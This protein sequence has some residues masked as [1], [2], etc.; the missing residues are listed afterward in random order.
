MNPEV[1]GHVDLQDNLCIWLA[2][3]RL[4]SPASNHSY[5]GEIP[6]ICS[7]TKHRKTLSFDFNKPTELAFTQESHDSKSHS[8]EFHF[9]HTVGKVE[10]LKQNSPSNIR[11]ALDI[12]SSDSQ[13]TSSE[14]LSIVKSGSALT[15]KTP[16]SVPR[17]SSSDLVAGLPCIY[18]AA[19]ISVPPG[20]TLE[21]LGINTETL[22]VSFYPGLDYAI[23][24]CTEI[25]AHSSSLSLVTDEPPSIDISSRETSIHLNSGSVSG[26]YPLYDILDVSTISGSIDI[27]VEP[28]DA[29]KDN[30]QPAILRLSS[31]SGSIRALTSR[32]SV[33]AR[34]YQTTVK[35]LSGGIDATLLHGSRTLLRSLN[36]RIN[37]DLYPY[38][39]NNSRTDINTH[40]QSGSTDIT[41]HSSLSHPTDPIQ[42]LYSEHH[43]LSGS[44]NLWYPAEWQ[45]TVKS[46]S[47]SGSIDLEWDGLRVVKDEKRGWIKRTVE[48]V[49]GEGGS[50]LIASS[51]SG[52]VTLGGD[53]ERGVFAGRKA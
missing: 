11:I 50:Q 6:K 49:R 3:R 28:K 43:G 27:D 2:D 15:V 47:L 41:V 31:N 13:L 38:G 9:V 48:A 14:S 23:T 19:T 30:V 22:S 44:V 5:Y 37:A 25:N 12:R 17:A 7:D 20:T 36:G 16:R 24:N 39:H 46:S 35:S 1:A 21:N 53:G 8:P 29:N 26:S 40:C 34:D 33:P 4:Q 51:K 45:G 18:V 42:K 10:V 32:A 52:S